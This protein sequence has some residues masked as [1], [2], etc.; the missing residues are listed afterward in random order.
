MKWSSFCPFAFFC[1][2]LDHL[3]AGW[4]LEK[5]LIDAE[6]SQQ[7]KWDNVKPLFNK[8]EF[9]LHGRSDK[10]EQLPIK[11][12]NSFVSFLLHHRLL[13]IF[14]EIRKQVFSDVYSTLKK[15]RKHMRLRFLF[16]LIFLL[17]SFPHLGFQQGN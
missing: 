9:W 4:K 6:E 7:M 14:P 5:K 17:V 1:G 12:G 13:Q 15:R 16:L 2:A 11:F 10:W 8:P 3:L